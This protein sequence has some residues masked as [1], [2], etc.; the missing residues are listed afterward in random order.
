MKV[1]SSVGGVPRGAVGRV[2]PGLALEAVPV[3]GGLP[4][5]VAV[6]VGNGTGA[7]DPTF[8]FSSCGPTFHFAVW[9]ALRPST[10][11]VTVFVSF[12]HPG[13]CDSWTT[14]MTYS[15]TPPSRAV[16]AASPWVQSLPSM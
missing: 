2:A 11:K 1:T 14:C 5:V 3:A 6:A 13:F 15:A 4:G 16:P 12:P 8:R 10:V 7:P 9:A